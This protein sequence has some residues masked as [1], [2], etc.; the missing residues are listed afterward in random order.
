MRSALLQKVVL[1]VLLFVGSLSGAQVDTS[2]AAGPFETVALAWN[3]AHNN[4]HY[5]DLKQWY[6]DKVFFY[7]KFKS[8]A[9]CVSEKT[10]NVSPTKAF[11]QKIT[12]PVVTGNIGKGLMRCDFT[13]ER[14]EGEKVNTIQAYLVLKELNS[15]WMIV[16][17][18][19]KDTDLRLNIQMGPDVFEEKKA[20]VIAVSQVEEPLVPVLVYY[21]AGGA[22]VLIVIVLVVLKAKRKK[23]TQVSRAVE[24]PSSK[25]IEKSK[26][27]KEFEQFVI[28]KLHPEK[29]KKHVWQEAKLP[30][31]LDGAVVPQPEL[32][33][34]LLTEQHALWVALEC[35]FLN[36]EVR[37][38]VEL[39][40]ANQLID[41]N[42]FSHSKNAKVYIVLGAGGHPQ[43]PF[44]MYVVPLTEVDSNVVS[45]EFLAPYKHAP[46]ADLQFDFSVNALK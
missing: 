40:T 8:P 18:S 41:Y 5:T 26:E 25:P 23:R 43:M 13:I 35:K 11:F 44:E 39:A 12:S 16:A 21:A 32:V 17:E 28:R 4:W 15:H 24:H 34:Q 1:Y 10:R 38:R 2:A 37:G 6:A 31:E 42:T 7:G 45:A 30:E 22:L 9:E 36:K 46:Q 33:Y 27:D 29:F 19:D 20:T 3:E 14:T